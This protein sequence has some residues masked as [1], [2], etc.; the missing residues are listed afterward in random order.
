MDRQ[1]KEKPLPGDLQAQRRCP[2]WRFHGRG[3]VEIYEI[4][5]AHIAKTGARHCARGDETINQRTPRETPTLADW[6][7]EGERHAGAALRAIVQPASDVGLLTVC[8]VSG[9][10]SLPSHWADQAD[11]LSWITE[12]ICRP[13]RN[14]HFFQLVNGPSKKTNPENRS[15]IVTN[16]NYQPIKP[17]TYNQ[18]CYK[19]KLRPLS[20]QINNKF[21]TTWRH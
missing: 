13:G 9:L 5:P 6:L 4:C 3:L 20:R 2:Q 17:P 19:N 8:I 21:W 7:V 11:I 14:L 18:H 10:P 15:N 16:R 1:P 12:A